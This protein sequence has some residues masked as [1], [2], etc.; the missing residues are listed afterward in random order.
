MKKILFLLGCVIMLVTSCSDTETYADKRKKEDAAISLFLQRKTKVSEDLFTKPISVI[1]ET[2]FEK[3]GYK[4]NVENNEFVLFESTGV[5]MQI[6]REGCGEKIES[7]E[8]AS[9]LARFDEYNI[10][11]DT[12]QLSNNNMTFQHIPEKMSV[13]NSSGSFTGKFIEGNSIMYVAYS[14]TSVPGGWLVPFRYVKI[15][16]QNTPTDEI[17]KVRVIVPSAQGQMYASQSTYPCYYEITY[18]RGL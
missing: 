17:A 16:R 4:T 5:Y 11:E 3:A 1:S 12:L 14:S 2:D 6:V 10:L 9:V 8:T 18:Q 15:G 7:G 13:T